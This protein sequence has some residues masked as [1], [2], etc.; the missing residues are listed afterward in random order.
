MRTRAWQKVNQEVIQR[1]PISV[2]K[3]LFQ[4]R[5]CHRAPPNDRAVGWRK[6]SDRKQFDAVLFNRHNDILAVDLLNMRLLVLAIKHSGN[7][8][9]IDVSVDQPNRCAGLRQGHSEIA[10]YGRFANPA[11]PGRDGD[12]ILYAR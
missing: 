6:E 8:R 9:T 7:R 4:G 10:G 2:A 5:A 11:L 3:E 1:T 12:D